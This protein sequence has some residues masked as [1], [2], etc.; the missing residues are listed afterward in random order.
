MSWHE[1]VNKWIK[2]A[3]IRHAIRMNE[4]TYI[5]IEIDEL[6]ELKSNFV[7]ASYSEKT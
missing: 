7:N 3:Y 5:Y 6:N 4:H 1:T 2:P